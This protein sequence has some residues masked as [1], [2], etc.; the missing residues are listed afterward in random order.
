MRVGCALGG[1]AILVDQSA[2][3]GATQNRRARD[4][5]DVGGARGA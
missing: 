2:A 4:R 3:T 1:V 5:G